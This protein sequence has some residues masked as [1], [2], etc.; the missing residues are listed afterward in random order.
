MLELILVFSSI[1]FFVGVVGL[2]LISSSKYTQFFIFIMSFASICA[3]YAF[4]FYWKRFEP[5]YICFLVA[6]IALV[7][8]LFGYKLF[9]SNKRM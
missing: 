9:S 4:A 8:M 3:F 5:V 7:Q 2:A 1:L 6:V